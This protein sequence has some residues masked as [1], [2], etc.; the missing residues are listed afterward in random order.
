M[1]PSSDARSTG[2]RPSGSSPS[3]RRTSRQSDETAGRPRLV[4][5]VVVAVWVEA[6]GA[7]AAVVALVVV[8]VRGTELAAAS[9][10]LAVLATGLAA[11]LGAAGRALLA[12]RR[13]ARSPVI[14]V[15]V[16]I[17][18][19]AVA[20]WRTAPAPWPAVGV[21]LGVLVVAFLLQR[22]VVSWT[23]RTSPPRAAAGQ[24]GRR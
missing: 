20:S 17:A 11:V 22:S 24:E 1:P 14:T 8:V 4:W 9:V 7:A 3:G 21:A 23:D 18:A 13:W 6:L 10:A 16:L 15:H 19:M 12:G 5:A 2:S